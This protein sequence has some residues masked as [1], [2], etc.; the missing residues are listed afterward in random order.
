MFK[1]IGKALALVVA[2]GAS[3]AASAMPV[4]VGSNQWQ[5]VGDFGFVTYN[6]IAT[7]CA[8]SDGACTGSLSGIDLTG[9]TWASAQ[10]VFDLFTFLGAPIVDDGALPNDGQGRVTGPFDA[11]WGGNIFGP[12]LFQPTDTIPG[13]WDR[14]QGLTRSPWEFG[15]GLVAEAYWL[16]SLNNLV[17]DD[18]NTR[19]GRDPSAQALGGWFCD[20][21][22]DVRR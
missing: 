8:V 19:F 3:G 15:A 14:V 12:G 1:Q 21:Q 2:V 11:A 9:W 18:A 22:F 10:D 20:L 17:G 7:V 6:Q 16:N 5:Q 4:T 13:L